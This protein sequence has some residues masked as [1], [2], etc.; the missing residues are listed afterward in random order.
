[1][2]AGETRAP[3]RVRIMPGTYYMTAPLEFTP[4][5]S[6]T[7]DAMV[8][9]EAVH[10]GTVQLSG[11]VP[12]TRS[13]S[14]APAGQ[15]RFDVPAAAGTGWKG[16]GQ[17]YVNNKRAV[18][19]RHPNVNSPWFVKSQVPLAGESA[20]D[21]GK[22]AFTLALDATAWVNALSAGDRSR[23]I[24]NVMQS[25][26]D[27]HHR[28]S[29][30]PVPAGAIR[31]TPRAVS[32][33]LSWGLSQ[34]A[35]IENVESALDAP[36]EWLWDA[37]GVRYIPAAGESTTN[38]AA[39]MP[40]LDKLVVVR[41]DVANRKWVWNMWFSGITFAH[42]RHLLADQGA[43][44]SQAGV[45]VSAAFEV[46]GGVGI[47]IDNC[48]FTHTGGYGLWFRRSVRDSRVTDSNFIDMGGGGLKMGQANQS[49]TEL[50][51]G[52]NSAVGNRI[53]DT[54]KVFTGAVAVWLGQ[55][56]DNLVA[57]NAIFNTSYT[58]ISVG[59]TLGYG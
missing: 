13:A 58:G 27:G 5:D 11:G 7:S 34:R 53:S 46:D 8:Y 25:W 4:A 36:G 19:A 12:L 14:A 35:Y 44:D 21:Y 43:T 17:L 32:P 15:V 2:A 31:I 22:Q 40:V 24:V 30:E 37:G 54:G 29:T 28:F 3:V 16:G 47:V 48:T 45:D 38:L 41:G 55:G 50:P 51:T 39:V 33:F 26:T 56:F 10:W 59:W 18:L 49:P 6:G 52:A 20:D 57:Q 1:M 9:Y 42:T 23:A